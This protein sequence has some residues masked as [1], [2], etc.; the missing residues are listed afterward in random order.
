MLNRPRLFLEGVRGCRTFASAA[1][2]TCRR[3]VRGVLYSVVMLGE[4]FKSCD[5]WLVS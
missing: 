2:E 5:S 4:L 1:V 3:F